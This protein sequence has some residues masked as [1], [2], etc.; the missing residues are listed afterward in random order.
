MM[1]L[2]YWGMLLARWLHLI[3]AALAIG[4]P[5]FMRFVLLP[6]RERLEPS[7]RSLLHEAVIQRWRI[8]VHTMIVVF[9]A[10]GFWTFLGV[11][12]W[13]DFNPEMRFWF[14][15]LFGAKLLIAL[16]MFFISSALAGRSNAFAG[17]RANARLWLG[18]LIVLG[19]VLLLLSGILR[20]MPQFPAET[21]S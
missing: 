7:Q 16:V 8:F 1:D 9:L 15:L 11:R 12:R 19:L 13:K 10:S 2:N 18:V 6:A 21:S 20:F 5:I 4:V 3:A 17:M 14:H